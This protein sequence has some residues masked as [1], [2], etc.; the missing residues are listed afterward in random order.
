MTAE[1]VRR[2]SVAP[3]EIGHV[4]FGQMVQTEPRDMYGSFFVRTRKGYP[5][6]DGR[7]KAG[8]TAPAS[9]RRLCG[10]GGGKDGPG[11]SYVV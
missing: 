8:A 3:G 6:N 1:A 11:G 9:V 5:S 4:L 7:K 10:L 2:S